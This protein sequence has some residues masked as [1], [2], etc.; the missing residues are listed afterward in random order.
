M[1]NN[2]LLVENDL[3][4]TEEIGNY[5]NIAPQFL[6]NIVNEHEYNDL[7][8]SSDPIYLKKNKENNT[9]SSID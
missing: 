1:D 2:N 7:F 3:I 9:D 5:L 4:S 6:T 8:S